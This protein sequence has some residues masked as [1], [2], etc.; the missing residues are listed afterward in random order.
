MYTTPLLTLTLAALSTFVSAAPTDTSYNPTKT[1]TAPRITHTV[2]AGRGGLKFEPD[3]IVAEKG[4]IVE[5]HFLPLNH[6]VVESS[7]AAPC[8]P[9][10]AN[11]FFSGFFPTREGQSAEVFQI[12]VKDTSKPIWF[13]CAQ[14]NGR[15]CQSGMTGVINQNFDNQKFSLRAHREIAAGVTAPS[16]VQGQVEGGWRIANPNPLGGV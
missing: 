2:V 12:E 15:H 8:Q 3:N 1:Y 9:K 7:F 4:S 16:G 11:S 10:D 13:Y 6:S 5:F 14:N